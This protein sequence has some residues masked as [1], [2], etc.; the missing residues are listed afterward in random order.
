M[1]ENIEITMNLYPAIDLKNG[2]AVR[3]FKGRFDDMT[4]YDDNPVNRAKS[5]ADIGFKYLHMVDLDGALAG[6]SVNVDV[7]KN[8]RAN[9]DIPIQLGG[10]IRTIETIENWLSI[11]VTRVILGTIAAKNPE[12]VKEAAKKFPNQI[13][14]GIDA[15]GGK[16]AI[17]GWAEATDIEANELAKRFEGAGVA[18]IIATDI[19]RDGTKTG[20][21]LEFTQ[22]MA[23]CVSI[24]VIASGG[25]K[26]VEDIIAIRKSV[27]TKIEGAILGK[28]L[29]DGLLDPKEA[30]LAANS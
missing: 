18:A 5:F 30:I 21:N 22:S 29:Y 23:D 14:V 1:V 4:V 17:E 20:I 24:P 28:A 26:G 9:I 2:K 12:F 11:G 13:A 8:I 7:V 3:L 6:K 27:G 10:G 15:I 25:L 19:D 16:V